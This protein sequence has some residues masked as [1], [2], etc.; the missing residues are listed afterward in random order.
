M[1]S[2]HLAFQVVIH[3]MNKN[4]RGCGSREGT[5]GKGKV[6]REGLSDEVL[7][8]QGFGGSEKARPADLMHKK[9]KPQSLGPGQA[10]YLGLALHSSF[11]LKQI[12]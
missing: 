3:A 8:D 6:T 2:E 4:E 9:V 7:F 11:D 5:V 1:I 10:Q 12:T